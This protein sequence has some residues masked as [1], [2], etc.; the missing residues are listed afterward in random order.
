MVDPLTLLVVGGAAVG[1][2]GFLKSLMKRDDTPR[3][4]PLYDRRDEVSRIG[5]TTRAAMRQ[6]SKDF[7]EHIEKETR[8]R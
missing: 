8:R 1:V 5:E 2:G 3:I 4:A 7:R 6:T